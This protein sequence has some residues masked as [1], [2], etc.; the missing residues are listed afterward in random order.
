VLLQQAGL[1]T[2]RANEKTLEYSKKQ[3]ALFKPRLFLHF[4]VWVPM[5]CHFVQNCLQYFSEWLPFFYSSQ[6]GI[7]PDLA[8]I[9]LITI[10]LVELPS[11]MITKDMPEKLLQRGSS[12]LQ[13]RKI[14]SVQGFSYHLLLC[15]LLAVFLGFDVTWPLPY[16]VLFA[17]SKATQSFHSGGY[18]ANYLDLTRNYTGMLTG[19]GN[20]VATCA[21]L[22]VP[23]FIAQ[24]LQI[25]D[26]NWLPVM[27]GMI[28]INVIAIAL[29]GKGM[30]VT[31]L[32]EGLEAS[33]FES[34]TSGKG[35][36]CSAQ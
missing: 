28:F 10:A 19:I 21:G 7:S 2:S 30:S 6:L 17:L 27:A 8:S 15:A 26:R 16:T 31:C 33:K 20:T 4:P 11:R 24:S 36:I 18:F 13:S 23:Q 12:L 9:H 35:R 34:E 1:V 29:V 22:V 3:R 5:V 14:M 32:D 25:D